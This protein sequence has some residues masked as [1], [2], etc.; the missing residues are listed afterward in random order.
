MGGGPVNPLGH[1]TSSPAPNPSPNGPSPHLSRGTASEGKRSGAG[2]SPK[3]SGA[4]ADRLRASLARLHNRAGARQ[5]APEPLRLDP[6]SPFEIAVSERLKAM[7]A[8]LEELRARVNW[9]LALIVGAAVT[10]I[11]IALVK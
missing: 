4:G 8:D 11:V 2:K 7:Q 10:N 9:L 6:C 1:Q 5:P 3:R